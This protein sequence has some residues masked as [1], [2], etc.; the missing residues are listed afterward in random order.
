MLHFAICIH[1]VFENFKLRNIRN[2]R[3]NFADRYSKFTITE[4]ANG[5]DRHTEIDY[6]VRDN[7][8]LSFLIPKPTLFSSVE[9]FFVREHIFPDVVTGDES[10]CSGFDFFFELVID[11]WEIHTLETVAIWRIAHESSESVGVLVEIIRH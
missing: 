10:S 4:E 7:S 5:N 9:E 6:L 1:L 3:E 2:S 8:P 11:G